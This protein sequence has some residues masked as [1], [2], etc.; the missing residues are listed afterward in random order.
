MSE[1]KGTPG[2][3]KIDFGHPRGLPGGISAKESR[4]PV[5]RFNTFARPTTPEALANAR[6]IAAAPELLEA[7]M[8]FDAY[9]AIPQD[10][11]GPTGPKGLAH[12]AWIDAKNAAI[13]KATQP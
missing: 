6:L 2:P 7:L 10:R 4:K 8:L 11:G 12:Q 1:F 3:W 5:T 9:L 13:K